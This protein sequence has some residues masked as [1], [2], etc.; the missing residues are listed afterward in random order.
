MLEMTELVLDRLEAWRAGDMERVEE[1]DA[2]APRDQV[3]MAALWAAFGIAE[4][5]LEAVERRTPGGATE[6]LA[7]Y[8]REVEAARNG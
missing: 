5:T 3:A 2:G 4:R 8:R 7:G 6:L 1:L